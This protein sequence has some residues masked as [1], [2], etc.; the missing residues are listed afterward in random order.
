GRYGQDTEAYRCSFCLPRL[1]GYFVGC[2]ERVSGRGVGR[3]NGGPTCKG[4]GYGLAWAG[5]AFPF[6]ATGQ[7][8]G[9]DIVFVR[10][11]VAPH[12]RRLKGEPE[13]Q[14]RDD[15]LGFAPGGIECRIERHG[16]AERGRRCSCDS[17]R[18][19]RGRR[20]TKRGARGRYCDL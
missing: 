20:R 15:R 1:Q 2:F 6:C 8:S 19:D 3:R 18:S 13:A 5:T 16:F 7:S 17:R 4:Y 14:T 10:I 11:A 12:G 9:A